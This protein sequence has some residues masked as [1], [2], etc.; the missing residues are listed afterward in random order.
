MEIS[1]LRKQRFQSYVKL[2]NWSSKV[3]S[4]KSFSLLQ[5]DIH[6]VGYIFTLGISGYISF[7][8]SN[9]TRSKATVEAGS[10]RS[11]KTLPKRGCWTGD[12]KTKVIP[13]T[14]N[15]GVMWI[16]S[17]ALPSS[18]LLCKEIR[19]NDLKNSYSLC[20]FMNLCEI[21]VFFSIN[22]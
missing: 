1:D 14:P 7:R 11:Q 6:E 16:I 10:I 3:K 13:V 21:F 2:K 19:S 5:P 12:Q 17:S 8:C 9:I 18:C 20:S 4:P 22:M 15:I